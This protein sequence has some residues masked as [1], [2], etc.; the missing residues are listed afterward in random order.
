MAG[1]NN[2]QPSFLLSRRDSDR[3]ENLTVKYF[4][5]ISSFPLLDINQEKRIAR[6]IID[7]EKLQWVNILSHPL[8]GAEFSCV[9]GAVFPYLQKRLQFI[10]R[11]ARNYRQKRGKLSKRQWDNYRKRVRHLASFLRDYDV[12]RIYLEEF[13]YVILDLDM[14]FCSRKEEPSYVKRIRTTNATIRKL[15][16][17]FIASNLR[18]VISI[19]RKHYNGTLPLMDLVQEGNLGLLKAIERFKP[20]MGY[21]FST[22]ASWWIRHAINRA[23]ADKSRT[24]RLPVHMID[25]TQKIK[26]VRSM[27]MTRHG[28]EPSDQELADKI[29]I[30]MKKLRKVQRQNPGHT[31]SL[32]KNINDNSPQRFI[33]IIHDTEKNN[34]SEKIAFKDW[35]GEIRRLLKVLSPIEADVV[36][37][38]YGIENEDEL[39]LKEIGEKY[40]LSRERIRQIQKAAIEKMRLSVK[41]LF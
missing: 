33:D 11:T 36:R 32:D 2:K 26:K 4:R 15:K 14:D 40:N 30:N 37:Y 16:K 10:H 29:G 31:L 41:G 34:P 9:L 25:A 28:R 39:T 27:T 1:S 19:A 12:D 13:V 35:C 6:Q 24:V 38:R 17:F 7:L 8:R 18:L 22:Y 3:L 21:R 5:E 23:L 20:S